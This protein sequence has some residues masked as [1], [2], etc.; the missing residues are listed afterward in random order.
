MPD[1]LDFSKVSTYSLDRLEPAIRIERFA[2]PCRERSTVRDYFRGLPTCGSGQVFRDMIKILASIRRAGRPILLGVGAGVID[3]GL[4]PIII[5]LLERSLV[6]GIAMTGNAVFRDVEIA[7]AGGLF[8]FSG[9]GLE[10]LLS[11]REA[12]ELINNGVNAGAEEGVGFGEA[13]GAYLRGRELPYS[14]QSILVAAGINGVPLTVH[15][16]IGADTAHFLPTASGEAI[17]RTAH[18]DFRIF[19]AQIAD[20]QGGIYLNSGSSETLPQVFMKALLVARALGH[21][22]DDF[23]TVLLGSRLP[24]E[25]GVDWRT[26]AAGRNT[27]CICVEGPYGL[28][29]PLTLSCLLDELSENC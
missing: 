22:V 6:T 13:L 8:N 29:F 27:P 26:I 1:P 14:D 21:R 25:T 28:L 12:A 18:L 19:S 16:T 7:M 11:S 10:T 2:R 3:E 9:A 23:Y 5:E 4:S 20:L 17:G 15:L 24:V